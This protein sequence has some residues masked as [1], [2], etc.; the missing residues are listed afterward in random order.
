MDQFTRILYIDQPSLSLCLPY[1]RSGC[2][3]IGIPE[4]S[5]WSHLPMKYVNTC[6]GHGVPGVL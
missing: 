3:L 6:A 2:V 4:L 5:L 1:G